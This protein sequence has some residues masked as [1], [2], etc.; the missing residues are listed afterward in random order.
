[1]MNLPQTPVKTLEEHCKVAREEGLRYVYI[2]NVPGHPWEHTYCPECHNVAIKRY[3]FDITGWNL[4]ENNRC[5]SCSYQL[6][7]V[8][9]LSSA[10]SEE[11][12]LPVIN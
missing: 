5:A 10:V 9:G 4:D 2:G 3:G 8:G 6:P 7:I 1:M 12:F 11:R